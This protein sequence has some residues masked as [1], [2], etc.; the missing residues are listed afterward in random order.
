[1]TWHFPQSGTTSPILADGDDVFVAQQVFLNVPLSG[2]Y[3]GHEVIVAGTVASG[4]GVPIFLGSSPE[5]GT[6]SVTVEATGQVRAFDASG[7]VLMG[8]GQQFVNHGLIT[9]EDATPV[10]NSAVYFF[11]GS[12]AAD[13]TSSFVNTGIVNGDGYGVHHSAGSAETF[14]VDNSGTITGGLSSFLAEGTSR[15]EITNSGKMIGDVA[16]GGGDDLYDGR[17]GTIDGDVFGGEGG[18]RLYS[19]EGNDRLFGQEGNDTLMGG[20]GADYLSGGTGTDRASY[21]SATKA[22]VVSLSNPSINSGDAKGD[23]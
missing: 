1:M 3:S 15:D 18:D 11:S 10:G 17:L 6:N 2:L 12:V 7:V 21:A 23:T 8:N 16:L 4:N 13:T 22:V 14:T 9:E 5:G 19:G 20:A